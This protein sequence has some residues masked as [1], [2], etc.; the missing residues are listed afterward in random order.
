MLQ[1]KWVYVLVVLMF[2]G[3]AIAEIS[4][5]AVPYT[6]GEVELEGYLAIPEGEPKGAVLVVHEWWGLNDYAKRRADML[7]ELGYVAFAVD[8]YGKG[9]VTDS[10][11]Q[12]GQWA[13]AVAGDRERYRARALAGL[14]AFKATGRI[15]DGMKIGAIGYCYGGTTVTELAYSGADL[16]GVVSFH[17]GP[18]PPLDTDNIK[19]SI[20]LCH[21]D[22][23]PFLSNDKLRAVLDAY[24]A[25][26]V[27][28]MLIRYAYA[29]HAFT[30]PAADSHH[31]PG[32]SY[33]AKADHRS[34]SHMQSFFDKVLEAD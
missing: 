11:E 26:K 20:L 21:G 8:M 33:N 15:T 34:W 16:A 19:A 23:D 17:G 4:T 13:G 25:K 2:A 31:I 24:N 7:A 12:A 22:A 6:H 1:V 14:D 10:A 27:D 9:M 3:T 32:V 5:E 29:Q 30:N 28:W 18:K